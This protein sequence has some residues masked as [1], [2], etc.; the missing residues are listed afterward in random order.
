MVAARRDEDVPATLNQLTI[1]RDEFLA[2]HKDILAAEASER[3]RLTGLDTRRVDLVV[4][5]SVVLATI[6]ELFRFDE[7]T[8]S[9]WALREGIALDAAGHHDPS[10]WS[11][12]PHAIRGAAVEGLARRCNSPEHHTRQVTHLVLE[13]F[14]GT[15]SV[16]GLG[17]DDRELL[18]FAAVLHDIGE[19]VASSGHHKHGAYLIR[20]GQLRGFAPVEIELLA[21]VVRWHRRGEPRVSDEFPLLDPASMDRVRTLVALLRVADGL[22]RSRTGPV[23]DLEVTVTPSLVLLRLTTTG[24][25]ELE[26]WG[27]RRKR[28]LLERVLDREIELTTH[29]AGRGRS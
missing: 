9:E 25:H 12:D 7:L 19:H 26:L 24:D 16:H 8:I 4:A 21:A 27:A 6:M 1:H 13:L 10:E 28:A 3:L 29:P 14:D 15:A 22:D 20:N 2:L 17:D 5:G 11:D 18:E 23:R